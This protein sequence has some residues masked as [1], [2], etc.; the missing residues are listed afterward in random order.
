MTNMAEVSKNYTVYGL[1]E[2]SWTLYLKGVKITDGEK[3]YR[4]EGLEDGLVGEHGLLFWV[5]FRGAKWSDTR[6]SYA[7]IN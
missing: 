4:D 2:C 3:A 5:F 6:V 7:V 1:R